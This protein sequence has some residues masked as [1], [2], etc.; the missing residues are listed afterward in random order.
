MCRGPEVTLK[1]SNLKYAY[2]EQRSDIISELVTISFQLGIEQGRREIITE[3]RDLFER[4]GSGIDT[5]NSNGDIQP[6]KIIPGE[7]SQTCSLT[8]AVSGKSWPINNLPIDQEELCDAVARACLDGCEIRDRQTRE[9]LT[10][11]EVSKAFEPA[12]VAGIEQGKKMFLKYDCKMLA[13]RVSVL[14]NLEH[15]IVKHMIGVVAST[16][17]DFRESGL[18]EKRE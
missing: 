6:G 7:I 13:D 18:W 2:E 11:E 9:Q 5:L 17:A 3:N 1:A 15:E 10:L 12:V 8:S 14:S 16:L 4:I